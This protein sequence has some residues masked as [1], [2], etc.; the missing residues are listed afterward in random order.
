MSTCWAAQRG[1]TIWVEAT[2]GH[3]SSDRR[4]VGRLWIWLILAVIIGASVV[5]RRRA[6]GYEAFLV[7]FSRRLLTRWRSPDVGTGQAGL[8]RHVIGNAGN[9]HAWVKQQ[10]CLEPQRGLVVEHVLPP[11]SGHELG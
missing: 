5:E 10:R 8:A 11:M 2:R 3:S 7:P 4:A 9:D 6:S 1:G